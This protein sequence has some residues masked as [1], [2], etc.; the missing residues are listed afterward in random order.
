MEDLFSYC[1]HRRM[2]TIMDKTVDVFEQNKRFLK[3]FFRHFKKKTFLSITNPPSI[4]FQ[5]CNTLRGHFHVVTTLKRGEG[6][7]MS[8]LEIEKLARLTKQVFCG[9]C[10]NCFCP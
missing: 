10:L 9:E 3:A 5:C 6:A 7:E 8:K 1:R 4:A 2:D